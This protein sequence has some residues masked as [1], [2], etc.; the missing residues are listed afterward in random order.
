[1]A[2]LYQTTGIV[3]SRKDFREADRW[4]S[5]FT[6]DKGKVEFIAR[7]GHKILAK[8]TP[9]LEMVAEVDLLMVFGKTFQTIAGVERQKAYPNIYTDFSKQSLAQSALHL[10]DIGTSQNE[11]DQAVYGLI[12]SWLNFLEEESPSLSEERSGYILASFFWKLMT[13]VGYGPE[14]YSCLSCHKNIAEKD[15]RWHTLRGGV[16]C[17]ACVEMD[18]E[19]WFSA[20]TINDETLKLVRFA[21]QESFAEQLKPH[22]VVQAISDFHVLTE[23]FL[24]SHFPTIPAN[25]LRQS[26]LVG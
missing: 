17:Q 12:Q 2:Y 10:V 5:V 1:M 9:H 11:H 3:L 26:C 7:G 23:S 8:L 13:I 16:V 20:R 6:K 19:Q 24:I 21:L 15:Y 4:Y 22:L 18:Q 14:L 25:S